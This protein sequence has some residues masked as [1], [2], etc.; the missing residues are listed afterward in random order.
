MLLD[1]K[2]WKIA[3]L[4][5]YPPRECGLATFTQDLITAIDDVGTVETAVI[6]VGNSLSDSYDSK[7]KDSIWQ[8][9]RKDY[10]E[11]AL[12]LNSSDIDLLVI[13]HEYGIYGGERGEYLLDLFDKLKMPVVTTFHTI[14][15]EPD[16]KQLFIVKTLASRLA[17]A[18]EDI[19]ALT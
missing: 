2:H 3:F 9:E 1:M 12:K 13:E 16:E 5:T 7:V 19:R 4:S 8:S 11:L 18:N 10:E 6:A 17:A 14:L 15:S